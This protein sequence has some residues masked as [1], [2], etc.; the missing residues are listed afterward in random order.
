MKAGKALKRCHIA[1]GRCWAR[2]SKFLPRSTF[3][4]ASTIIKSGLIEYYV[5][6]SLEGDNKNEKSKEKR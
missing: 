1:Q 2:C 5:N 6:K 3:L 4:S